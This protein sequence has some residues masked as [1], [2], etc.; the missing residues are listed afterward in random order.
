MNVK[1]L[2]DIYQKRRHGSN[3]CDDEEASEAG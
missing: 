3:S 1:E 2:R